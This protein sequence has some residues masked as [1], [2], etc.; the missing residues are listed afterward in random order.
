[1]LKK[2]NELFELNLKDEVMQK[3]ATKNGKVVLDV[4]E[5]ANCL[6]LLYK[7]GAENVKY[8][9]YLNDNGYPCFYNL[10][11]ENP[12]VRVWVEIDTNRFEIEFPVINGIYS[13]ANPSNLEIHKSQQRAFVKAVA[14]NTGLGLKLWIKEEKEINDNKNLQKELNKESGQTQNDK[15]TTLFSEALQIVGDKDMLYDIILLSQE[16]LVKLYKSR[17]ISEKNIVIKQLETV[18]SNYDKNTKQ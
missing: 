6:Q 10:Q 13:I 2:F 7:N 4:L 18:I 11:G 14:I 17:D 16:K 12:F 15:I 9:S 1:M 3:P 8:G 5:W